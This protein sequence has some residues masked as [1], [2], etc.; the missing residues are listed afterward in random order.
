MG[1]SAGMICLPCLLRPY[2]VPSA[3]AAHASG[4]VVQ[5]VGGRGLPKNGKR[6]IRVT[7]NTHIRILYGPS[8]SRYTIRLNAS[9]A[10]QVIVMNILRRKK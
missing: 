3:D 5:A 8:I 9:W 4:Q 10:R 6:F 1:C 2:R 7:D